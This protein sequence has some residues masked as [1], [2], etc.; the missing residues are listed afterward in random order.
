MI[1]SVLIFKTYFRKDYLNQ[2]VK[3]IYEYQFEKTIAYKK[4]FGNENVY[5][6][7][8]DADTLMRD[9]LFKRNNYSFDC[10]L[11]KDT[12]V[13]SLKYFNHFVS[14]LKSDFL[15]MAS[16]DPQH[17][18]IAMDYFSNRNLQAQAPWARCP[19]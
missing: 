18:A 12:V 6:I 4:K 13:K 10:Q 3:N 8:F 5:A 15:I 1:T 7:Y 19:G 11:S 14:K 16:S 2:S 17:Q 9:V